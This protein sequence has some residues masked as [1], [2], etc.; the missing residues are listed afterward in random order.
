MGIYKV[1]PHG[2]LEFLDGMDE[3]KIEIDLEGFIALL[4]ALFATS[5]V[6]GVTAYNIIEVV[7]K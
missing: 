7:Y 4:I 2:N 3:M 6:I 5:I 1:D